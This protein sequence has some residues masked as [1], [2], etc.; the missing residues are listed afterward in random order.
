MILVSAITLFYAG[1]EVLL[2]F[3]IRGPYSRGVEWP[4]ILIGSIATVLLIGGYIPVPFEVAKRRGRVVGIDFI[5]LAID[6]CGAF[7]SLMALGKSSSSFI[8]TYLTITD[9][10]LTILILQLRKIPLIS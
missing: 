4:V 5:F 7:F 10:L 1:M 6:W 9:G 2:V 3:V 8:C